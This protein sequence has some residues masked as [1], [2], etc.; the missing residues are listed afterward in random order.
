MKWDCGHVWEIGSLPTAMPD[1]KTKASLLKF[2]QLIEGFSDYLKFNNKSEF[3]S[4]L[5]K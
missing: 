5:K 2:K 1:L 3:N 4:N